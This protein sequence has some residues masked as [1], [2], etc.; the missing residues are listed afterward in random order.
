V[1][2]HSSGVFIADIW[3]DVDENTIMLEKIYCRNSMPGKGEIETSLK[4]SRCYLLCGISQVLSTNVNSFQIFYLKFYRLW[5]FLLQT[6]KT[7]YIIEIGKNHIN[8]Y[9]QISFWNDIGTSQI[10]CLQHKS[11]IQKACCP[12]KCHSP[13]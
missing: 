5:R 12:G 10:S 1:L 2:N 7:Y 3:N 13:Q 4:P 9:I 6:G 8:Q 11:S